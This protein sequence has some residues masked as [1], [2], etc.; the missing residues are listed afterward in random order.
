VTTDPDV[1]RVAVALVGRAA[2]FAQAT[3]SAA[4]LELDH[5]LMGGEGLD[6]GGRVLDSLELSEWV[7]ALEEDLDVVLTELDQIDRVRTL[8]SLATYLSEVAQPQRL[9]DFCSE[10]A[11]WYTAACRGQRGGAAAVPGHRPG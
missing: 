2:A 5:D 1:E 10:W 11:G 9:A 4:V 8:R 6:V 3:P 7:F